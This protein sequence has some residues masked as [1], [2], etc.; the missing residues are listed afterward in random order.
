MLI[1]R[2]LL[3]IFH[4]VLTANKDT[5]AT[6]T[7]SL[8]S[9]HLDVYLWNEINLVLLNVINLFHLLIL[10]LLTHYSSQL[11]F[12]NK[13]LNQRKRPRLNTV[14]HQVKLSTLDHLDSQFC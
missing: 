10:F 9:E 2:F 14:L 3:V 11:L 5:L 12:M 13:W 1:E 8:I 6:M 7:V 4:C